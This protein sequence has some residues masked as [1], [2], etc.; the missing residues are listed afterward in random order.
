M[1]RPDSDSPVQLSDGEWQLMQIVWQQ[2][3][4]TAR[5]VLEALP[6]ENTWAYSTVKTML[7][8]LVEKDVIQSEKRG[9]V[10][11]YEPLVSQS[12][13]RRTAV[14]SFLDKAFDG[15]FAPLMRFLLQDGTLSEADRNEIRRLLDDENN[16]EG[17]GE[18]GSD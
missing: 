10:S 2:G 9:N 1:A 17:V 6:A 4:V 12:Q 13:A 5:E 8:R 18:S 14:R 11:F 3:S 7:D 16:R 15:A